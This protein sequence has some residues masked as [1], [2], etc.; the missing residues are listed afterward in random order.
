MRIRLLLTGNELMSGD[1]V[2]SNSAM[3]AQCLSEY[4]LTID[5][6]VTV[7]DHLPTLIAEL[8]DLARDADVLLVNGGL[9]PTV[10]DLTAEALAAAAGVELAEQPLALEHLEH[11]CAKLGLALNSANRKQA[12]LPAGCRILPNPVG[13]AVGFALDIGQC[14][15]LCTPGV[16]RELERML[17]DTILPQLARGSDAVSIRKLTF[18]GIGESS[19]Q[20]LVTD[21]LSPWPGDVELG[22]RAGFPLM[23]LKLTTRHPT[24]EPRA[25][26]MQQRIVELAGEYLIA[27]GAVTMAQALVALL[28][29]RGRRICVAESC[30]GGSIATELTRIPGASQVFEAGFVTYSN[31]MKTQLLGVEP[32]LLEQH[33]AVSEPVVRAMAQGALQRSGAD[34]AISVSGIA[35][36]DGGSE[37]KPVGT[38]WIAWGT[39]SSL[40][41]HRFNFRL[42]RRQFQDLTTTVALDLLR[43]H[44]LG[45]DA[46]AALFRDRAS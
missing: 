25:E 44:V 8:R 41:A 17:S 42:S 32:A 26:Q 23:E 27:T 7:G 33:G 1:I 45:I 16:P 13:T 2:D 15:V 37:D 19:L 34:Y 10:D 31:R 35:G 18:F 3:I 9:G 21:R 38:V 20:Q 39:S 29:E 11:W 6:K 30:T 46:P 28:T 36:P 4:G 43:R 40:Q 24:A 22:F 14:Q 12:L 5:K